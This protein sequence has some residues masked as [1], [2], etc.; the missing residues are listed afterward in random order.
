MHGKRPRSPLT[1]ISYM[2]QGPARSLTRLLDQYRSDTGIVPPSISSL[3]RWS[4]DHE[5]QSRARE[6]DLA[7]QASTSEKA[8]EREAEERV[9]VSLVVEGRA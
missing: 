1:S 9:E 3:K 2:T 6:H 8:I 5:W 4:V 7:V